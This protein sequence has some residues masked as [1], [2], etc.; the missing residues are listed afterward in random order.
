MSRKMRSL[1][2]Q[3]TEEQELIEHRDHDP[4]PFAR[5]ARCNCWGNKGASALQV[6]GDGK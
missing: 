1:R 6:D 4:R 3:S 5:R 2:L